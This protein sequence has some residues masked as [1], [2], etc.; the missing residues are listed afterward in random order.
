MPT[1]WLFL[2]SMAWVYGDTKVRLSQDQLSF[3]RRPNRTVHISCKLSGIPLENAIVHWYQQKKGEPLRRILYGST[4][5]SKD[6]KLNPRMETYRKDGTFNLIIN[7]VVKS[8]EAIYYCACWDPTMSQ[9]HQGPV[10][11]PSLLLVLS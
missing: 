5:N 4:K 7:N 3:I 8:D 11:K 2:V 10:R 9:S 6:N 1:L